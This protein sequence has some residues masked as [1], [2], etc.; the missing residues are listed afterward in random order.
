VKPSIYPAFILA[1]LLI[2]QAKREESIR[3]QTED[4][5]W[6]SETRFQTLFTAAPIGIFQADAEGNCLFMNQQCLQIM[7]AKLPEVLGQGWGNFVHPDDRSW[8]LAQ[9]QETLA[10]QSEFDAD[11][12]FVTPQGQINWVRVKASAT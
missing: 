7:G 11:Y 2:T 1:T 5:L 4:S 12:R 3:Q 8:V 10:T 6:T 9:W